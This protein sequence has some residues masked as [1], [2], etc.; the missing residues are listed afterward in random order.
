[1]DDPESI[2]RL[3]ADARVGHLATVGSDGSPHVVVVCFALV[4]DTAYTAVDHKP[5]RAGELRRVANIKA[6]AMASLLVDRYDEDWSALWW[7]RL[8][9]PGRV[10]EEPGETRRAV[11][12]LV[13]KYPQYQARPPAG[14]V[15]A[16]D[17][18]RWSGWS[19]TPR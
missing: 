17:V 6:T 1:M 11:A 16:V 7:V 15:L 12:A 8:D 19:A 3:A 14:P 13:A 10:V 18:E 4:G 5:K 2:R 9:G